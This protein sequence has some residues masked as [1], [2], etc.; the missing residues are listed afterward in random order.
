V[1]DEERVRLRLPAG[2]VRVHFADRGSLVAA[3]VRCAR[4]HE[5][6]AALRLRATHTPCVL[7]RARRG[8]QVVYTAAHRPPN[9]PA[10]LAPFFT[11]MA[12]P[13]AGDADADSDADGDATPAPSALPAAPP[14]GKLLLSHEVD[15]RNTVVRGQS[16]AV[17]G[18]GM[19]AAA[20]A[21][22]ALRLGAAQARIRVSTLTW[23]HAC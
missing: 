5:S 1:S 7:I 14:T 23:P 8:A 3:Q 10:A 11:A 21:L 13:P 22:A 12:A 9:I 4:E 20:L 6:S 18:G 16:V 19:T 15:V 17:V 2:G